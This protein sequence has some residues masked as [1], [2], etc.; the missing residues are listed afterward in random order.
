MLKMAFSPLKTLPVGSSSRESEC[1]QEKQASRLYCTSRPEVVT[2]F[3]AMW[4]NSCFHVDRCELL[5][6][7]IYRWFFNRNM[8]V[9]SSKASR[10]AYVAQWTF[11][12]VYYNQPIHFNM[13]PFTSNCPDL[14]VE[15]TALRKDLGQWREALKLRFYIVSASGCIVYRL[16]LY[17]L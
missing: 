12:S 8:V 13:C 9:C 2:W 1:C 6:R 15:H 4:N 16:F 14:V 10:L 7:K 17:G 3:A 11:H 5:R